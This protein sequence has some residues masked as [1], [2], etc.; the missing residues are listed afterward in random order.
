MNDC[1]K[2]AQTVKRFCDYVQSLPDVERAEQGWGPKEILA[3][4]YTKRD[5]SKNLQMSC[6]CLSRLILS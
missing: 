6:K 1:E 4:L 2:L 5:P 3:Q